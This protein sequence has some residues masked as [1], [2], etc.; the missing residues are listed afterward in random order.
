MKKTYFCFLL[1]LLAGCQWEEPYLKPLM[2]YV[3][4][5]TFQMGRRTGDTARDTQKQTDDE[6]PH[7]VTVSGF[8]ICKYEV[9]VEQFRNFCTDTGRS[10]PTGQVQDD[11]PVMN[12]TWDDAVA[13]C[14]WLSDKTGE[15]YRLPTEA[16]WEYAARGGNKSA[17]T[18]YAGGNTLS[19]VGWF[20]TQTVMP[21]GQKRP[22]ELGLYDMSGNVWE[23]CSDWYGP[24]TVSRE[25]LD[26]P[27]GPEQRVGTNTVHV[28][29][30]GSFMFGAIYCRV[31]FRGGTIFSTGAVDPATFKNNTLGFRVVS[32]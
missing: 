28:H 27:K 17:G 26:N 32:Q 20:N 21:V 13:Y 14:A 10:M 18:I 1:F 19:E 24:Y 30:G 7:Q 2:I 6:T 25:A 9:T 15:N 23:W 16:E 12:V 11:H 4:G 3:E 5:G 31:A 29:R 22:N 8:T